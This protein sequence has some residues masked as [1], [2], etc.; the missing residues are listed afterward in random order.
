MKM[1][2]ASEADMKMAI[3]LCTALE[4]LTGRWGATM[5]NAIQQPEGRSDS[6]YF[7]PDDSEQCKRVVA[8]LRELVGGASLMRVVWGMTVLLDP[9]NTMV[10]PTI[11][12][13]EH[14]PDTDAA[15]QDRDRLDWLLD[16]ALVIHMRH[17]VPEL[18]TQD[19]AGI[20]AAMHAMAVRAA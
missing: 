15:K 13:L 12:T 18:A 11:D 1:A 19:R 14:H 5:P 10:D 7:D 2:K 6:E 20:A 4:D 3:E 16:N 9:R 17:G 8:Y